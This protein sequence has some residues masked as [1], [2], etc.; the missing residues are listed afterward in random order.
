MKKV[1]T[2]AINNIFQKAQENHQP[3]LYRGRRLKIYY[4]TQVST[5]PP[6]FLIFVNN[7][8]LMRTSYLNY[9]ENQIRK[10]YRFTGAPIRLELRR[11]GK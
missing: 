2:P 10:R 11:R 9:L 7:P 6:K 8:D 5:A 3:P 1:S 4:V